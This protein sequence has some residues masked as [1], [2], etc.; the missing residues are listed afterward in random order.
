MFSCSPSEVPTLLLLVTYKII[1]QPG[2]LSPTLPRFILPLRFCCGSRTVLM[3]TISFNLKGE[4]ALF[5]CYPRT[6]FFFGNASSCKPFAQ[7]ISDAIFDW[8][9]KDSG[10][11]PVG[12]GCWSSPFSFGYAVCVMTTVFSKCV[13]G[14]AISA[15]FPFTAPSKVKKIKYY[16]QF[17]ILSSRMYKEKESTWR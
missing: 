8:S 14:H 6:V 7:F 9:R 13:E 3:C 12:K 5:G 10:Y 17:T 11:L 2:S 1:F 15:W 16:L 4:E